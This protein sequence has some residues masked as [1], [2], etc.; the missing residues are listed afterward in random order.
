MNRDEAAGVLC[1]YLD[2]WRRSITP[3]SVPACR[4]LVGPAP[5]SM[6]ELRDLL[7]K[8]LYV[9][10]ELRVDEHSVRVLTDDDEVDLA[11]FFVD[12]QLVKKSKAA[13]WPVASIER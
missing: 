13:S 5:Q 3:R 4:S 12:G 11:Y 1:R 9:E 7:E 8:H 10:Q 2:C 6:R